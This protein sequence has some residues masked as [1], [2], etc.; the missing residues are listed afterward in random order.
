MHSFESLRGNFGYSLIALD[1]VKDV[2]GTDTANGSGTGGFTVSYT[3]TSDG[4]Y[5]LG[6]A[7]NNYFSGSVAKAP[8]VKSGNPDTILYRN[9]ASGNNGNLHVHGDVATAGSYTNTY[10]IFN[11]RNTVATVAFNAVPEPATL[12]LLALGGLAV[13]RKRRKQ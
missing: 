4:G 5:V 12:S 3:T 10:E 6:A 13:L 7:I 8:N 11:Q 1:N 9:I 2:A